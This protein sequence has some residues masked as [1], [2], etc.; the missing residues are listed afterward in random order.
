ML[1][2]MYI[3]FEWEIDMIIKMNQLNMKVSLFQVESYLHL[4]TMLGNIQWKSFLNLILKNT[5]M[6]KLI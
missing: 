1:V 5:K 2:I 6:M 3:W 4:K